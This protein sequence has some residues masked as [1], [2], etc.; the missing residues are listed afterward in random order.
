VSGLPDFYVMEYLTFAQ[1]H[2][3]G[4]RQG[5]GKGKGKGK[6]ARERE[7]WKPAGKA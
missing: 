3:K 4:Q 7:E 1:Q 6:G 2:H 5:K